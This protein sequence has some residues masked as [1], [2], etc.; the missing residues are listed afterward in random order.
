MGFEWDNEMLVPSAN[1]IG[2]DIS[3]TNLG[4][5]V[6]ETR[7]SKDSKTAPWGAPCLTSAQ[8]DVVTSF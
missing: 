1:T 7:K 6:I 8:V 3:L 5:S 4:T 2:T